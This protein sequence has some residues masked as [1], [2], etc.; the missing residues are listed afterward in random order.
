MPSPEIVVVL[1]VLWVLATICVGM[2]V[3]RYLRML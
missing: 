2:V 1:V 3:G